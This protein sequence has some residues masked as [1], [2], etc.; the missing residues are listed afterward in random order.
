MVDGGQSMLSNG[1]SSM[2]VDGNISLV[3]KGGSHWSLIMVNIKNAETD[4]A[5][6]FYSI[7]SSFSQKFHY[8]YNFSTERMR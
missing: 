7:M 5:K 2:M 3:V 8:I 4:L 6:I 1:D